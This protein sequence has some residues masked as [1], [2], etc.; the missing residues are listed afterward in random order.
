MLYLRAYAL[1]QMG[2]VSDSRIQSPE[3]SNGHIRAEYG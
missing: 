1:S 3:I 2:A